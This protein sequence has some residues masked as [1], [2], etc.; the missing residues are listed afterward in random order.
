MAS[1]LRS[2]MVLYNAGAT[3][4]AL[5]Y[6]QTSNNVQIENVTRNYIQNNTTIRGYVIFMTD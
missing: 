2:N 3:T 5:I 6:H 4:S 1:A